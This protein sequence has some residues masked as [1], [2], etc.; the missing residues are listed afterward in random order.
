MRVIKR[1]IGKVLS[2]GQLRVV[3]EVVCTN[4]GLRLELSVTWV[5][6]G[7][8]RHEVEAILRLLGKLHAEASWLFLIF[9]MRHSRHGHRRV[10]LL[11]LAKLG[12]M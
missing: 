4:K 6:D 8:L 11:C 5:E 3:Q 10:F 9:I 2:V 1:G 12:D 7:S